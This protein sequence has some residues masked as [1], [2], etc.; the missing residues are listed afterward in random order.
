MSRLLI[1]LFL[2]SCKSI[3]GQTITGVLSN[4][5][6]K[7]PVEY[8]NIGI[9]GKNVGTVTGINGTF[10]IYVDSKYNN[11]SLL[12]SII[13]YKPRYVK[14][15]DL[16]VSNYNKLYINEVPYEI[17]EVVVKPK[18]F[19]QQTLGLTTKN[20]K[21]AAGFNDNFLGYECG[22]LMKVKKSAVLK[23]VN[24][25]FSSSSYDTI[26]Y[27]LNIYKVKG[28]MDFENILKEPVYIEISKEAVKDEIQIDLQSKNIQVHGNF[29]VTL[30]HVKNLGEG[31]L[32]FCA[33]LGGRTYSR[34]TSH[35]AWETVP[36]GISISVVADVEK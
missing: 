4:S 19:K 1:F 12:V 28:K 21:I 35:G 18:V 27:R 36:I 20:K 3:F 34:K 10:T 26:F 7:T 29:M 33:G 17:A 5:K 16:R 22:M 15:A 14:V 6:S 9:V 31:H 8:A 23:K 32:Y 25:N 13:G 2:I 30:E 24:L 11:D